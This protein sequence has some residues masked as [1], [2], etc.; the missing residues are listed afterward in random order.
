MRGDVVA[1]VIIAFILG[2]MFALM[3]LELTEHNSFYR[4]G[5]ID[6]I[7]G[8]VY[9]KL[10]KELDGSTMWRHSTTIVKP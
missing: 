5:Q 7:N 3:V 1:G 10:E 9:Y 6:C 4:D 8:A 2:C